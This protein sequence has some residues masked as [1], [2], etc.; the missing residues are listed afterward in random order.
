MKVLVT[1]AAFAALLCGPNAN[2]SLID[3]TGES[4][5]VINSIDAGGN[6]WNDSTLVFT[7]QLEDGDNAI[8]EGRFDWVSAGQPRGSEL[9]TGTLFADLSLVLFGFQLVD[10]VAIILGSY[11]A[12]V[13]SATSIVAGQWSATGGVPGVWEATRTPANG[14]E[15]PANDVP[16]TTPVPA[17][18]V[19]PLMI[20]GLVLCRMIRRQR[21]RG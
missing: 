1:I 15:P 17:P 2:A 21:H 10:P 11:A 9:F 16:P 12:T 4:W 6:D 7:S 8:L 20:G 18:P 14:Q 5:T 3:L 19:L 13:A